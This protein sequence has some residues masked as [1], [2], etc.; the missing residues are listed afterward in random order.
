MTRES[1]IR[2]GENPSNPE[3]V[4]NIAK[5]DLRF[6]L[7]RALEAGARHP[8]LF[9]GEGMT[10]ISFCD[11]RGRAFKSPRATAP[12]LRH[13][14][15]NEVEW[16]QTAA[17]VPEVAPHVPSRTIWH[18]GPGV[19]ERDCVNGTP[20]G[21]AQESKL[22]NLHG[23]IEKAMLP[24]GW[25]APE[26]KGDSY[27][28]PVDGGPPVLVDAGM[29]QRVGMR[30]VD[31]VV[32]VLNGERETHERLSDLAFYVRR[33]VAEGTIPK[34]VGAKVLVMIEEAG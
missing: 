27:I 8:L 26:F 12:V 5:D 11:S 7:D 17:K 28:F 19:I 31:Y 23:E 33:E 25:T 22:F 2:F 21:W 6:A 1:W 18:E 16:F 32:D 34:E 14:L 10:S 4:R 24:H 29:A 13:L 15:E 20:G 3:D 9:L 30:L